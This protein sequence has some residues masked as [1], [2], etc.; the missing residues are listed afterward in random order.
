MVLSTNGV[1]PSAPCI[2]LRGAMFAAAARWRR[3]APS[4]N[5]CASRS[6]CR[7]R[8]VELSGPND[9]S[10]SARSAALGDPIPH[11]SF[12]Y[13]QVAYRDADPGY[14]RPAATFNASNAVMVAW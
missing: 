2:Y 12:R 1:L 5:L 9:P 11:G 3:R 10:V 6:E 7:R 4:A 14:C 13:Y 8:F